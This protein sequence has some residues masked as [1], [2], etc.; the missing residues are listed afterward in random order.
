MVVLLWGGIEGWGTKEKASGSEPT[1]SMIA[2]IASP[3]S[4]PAGVTQPNGVARVT[5]RAVPPGATVSTFDGV[6]EALDAIFGVNEAS[7]DLGVTTDHSPASSA[8]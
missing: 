5:A 8:A 7:T 3:S 4:L 6:E 2:S 1:A